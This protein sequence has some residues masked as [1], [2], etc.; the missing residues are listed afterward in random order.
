MK[1]KAK[2]NHKVGNLEIRKG[3]IHEQSDSYAEML[4]RQGYDE[5][6]DPEV[7]DR[8]DKVDPEVKSRKNK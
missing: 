4:I 1:L 2:R 3:D 7:A 6:F 5:K 8:K